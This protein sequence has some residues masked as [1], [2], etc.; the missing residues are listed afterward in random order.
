MIYI[1]DVVISNVA[2]NRQDLKE[3]MW[4]SSEQSPR[5]PV[6][7]VEL[8][9]RS[10][11]AVTPNPKPMPSMVLCALP[12]QGIIARRIAR[13]GGF[14]AYVSLSK[15]PMR[16]MAVI[17]SIFLQPTTMTTNGRTDGCTHKHATHLDYLVHQS[18]HLPVSCSLTLPSEQ[19]KEE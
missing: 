18:M 1:V 17:G 3:C 12:C 6:K 19:N 14:R 13:Q 7:K 9:S 2:V 5:Q 16:V 8:Q 15:V 4:Q 10:S 11:L